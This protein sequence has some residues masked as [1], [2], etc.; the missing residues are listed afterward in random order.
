[1]FNIN[2]MNYIF[3]AFIFIVVA[4]IYN[5]QNQSKYEKFINIKDWKHKIKKYKYF[6][7][8]IYK[9]II[10]Q[11]HKYTICLKYID[12]FNWDKIPKCKSIMPD[13]ITNISNSLHSMIHSI[14]S[15]L[16]DEYNDLITSL[17]HILYNMAN[18]SITKFYDSCP[19]VSGNYFNYE[20]NTKQDW[21][22]HNYNQP[23]SYDPKYNPHYD[24]FV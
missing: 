7:I 12:N 15:S 3:V 8:P 14:P 21:F 10:C 17:P 5:Q 11:L 13:L 6:N 2:I 4:I 16:V 20:I 9:Q 18:E 19:Q 22:I 24:F 23:K 1:M